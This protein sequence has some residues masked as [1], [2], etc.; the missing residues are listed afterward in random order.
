[1]N[2]K[3]TMLLVAG[4]ILVL[5]SCGQ[6]KQNVERDSSIEVI[7]RDSTVNEN[8]PKL[9]GDQ[10]LNDA[11]RFVAGMSVENKESKLYGLTQT[12]EWK[13]HCKNMDQIWNSFL[14]SAP[15]VMAFSQSEL[16][17][18]NNQCKT[19]FYPFGGPDFLFPNTLFPEMDT[20]FLIGLEQAGTAIKVKHPSVAT[21]QLYQNAVSDILNLSFFRT[22][23]MKVEL[24]N[25][26]IDGVVPII[27]LLMARSERE[28]VS[29]EHKRLNEEGQ[30]VGTNDDGTPV[31]NH[32]KLV[33]IKYFKQG[34]R[35]LQTLYYLSTDLS[36]GGLSGNKPLMAYIDRFDKST[37][38]CFI[39]SAS[40][41]MHM[42][43]F[44]I[45]RNAVLTHVSSILQDDSGISWVF[46]DQSKWNIQLYGAFTGPISMFAA[47][48]QP[49]L[50]DAY[51]TMEPKPINFRMGYARQ[52]NLQ[53][54]SLKKQKED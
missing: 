18:V 5:S 9:V 21:Y 27:T 26:T 50:Q 30:I 40:Y 36:N 34:T 13:K 6:K 17:G 41:L 12:D 7:Q 47:Y 46:Y 22:K 39:K 28:I 19:L 25:D 54:S 2:I 24:S 49:D 35:K 23:D 33:E 10:E 42:T 11:A 44:S 4:M 1:M 31:N 37:T 15:K 45:I 16:S 32:S 48:P 43:Y 3:Y 14:Q 29:I 53:L 8:G 38:A 20:Y 51:Q 52:S